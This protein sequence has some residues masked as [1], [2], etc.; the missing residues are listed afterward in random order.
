MAVDGAEL[1]FATGVAG[2]V[3]TAVE[4][5]RS[6]PTDKDELPT[7]LVLGGD[8]MGELVMDVA[9]DATNVYIVTSGAVNAIHRVPRAG[10]PATRMTISS[11]AILSM[12]VHCRRR[13][14]HAR[15]LRRVSGPQDQR[16][17][18]RRDGPLDSGVRSSYVTTTGGKL[19][20]NPGCGLYELTRNRPRPANGAERRSDLGD[21]RPWFPPRLISFTIATDCGAPSPRRSP[22]RLFRPRSQID[23][24]WRVS[25]VGRPPVALTP[26]IRDRVA[27]EFRTLPSSRTPGPRAFR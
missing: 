10:G 13:R 25:G 1:F 23:L 26:R 20:A 17:D 24:A 2:G 16:P 14:L 6:S 12:V 22:P 19:Y 5:W 7:S 4:V 3:T 18:G 9:V 11:E 27:S 21:D 8:P 15:Q